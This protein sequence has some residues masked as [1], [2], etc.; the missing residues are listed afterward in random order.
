M[1]VVWQCISRQTGASTTVCTYKQEFYSF[2]TWFPCSSCPD[3]PAICNWDTFN[4]SE[5]N[6]H[7]LTGALVGGPDSNDNYVDS[8]QK[9]VQNMIACDINAAFQSAV[10]ALVDLQ[11]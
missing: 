4:S 2:T 5:P 10:A 7:T 8:R 6:F 1:L 11:L 3:A 9:P